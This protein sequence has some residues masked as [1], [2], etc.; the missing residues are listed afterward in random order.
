[1]LLKSNGVLTMNKR[2]KFRYLNKSLL[3]VHYKNQFSDSIIKLYGTCV[4][5]VILGALLLS[6][7]PVVLTL[8]WVVSV[9]T[10]YGM[11]MQVWKNDFGIK[12]KLFKFIALLS[13][14]TCLSG[15]VSCD[16]ILQ[17]LESDSMVNRIG[18]LIQDT[19][20]CFIME[21]NVLKFKIIINVISF[22]I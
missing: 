22:P 18:L 20:V 13:A 10:L 2:R 14:N 9:L 5:R 17:H 21:I 11:R 12:A 4:H 15:Y 3:F 16:K 7:L 8:T 19:C 6:Q 1:M